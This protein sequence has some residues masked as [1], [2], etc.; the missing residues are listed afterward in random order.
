MMLPSPEGC[1]FLI[2]DF[3]AVSRALLRTT[4]RTASH[5][6]RVVIMAARHTTHPE[7]IEHTHT[8]TLTLRYLVLQRGSR[9]ALPSIRIYTDV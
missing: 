8:H 6:R 2:I 9:I 3:R 5:H 1:V 4:L 7:A